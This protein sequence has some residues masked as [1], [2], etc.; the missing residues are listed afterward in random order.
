MATMKELRE[1]GVRAMTQNPP[2]DFSVADVN[3]SFREEIRALAGDAASFRRNKLDLFELMENIINDVLPQRVQ[4]RY[5]VWAEY[6]QIPNGAKAVFKKRL[7]KARA[8]SF[9]TKVGLD[10]VFETFRL[11]RTEFEVDTYGI[12]VAAVLSWERFLAGQEDLAEYLD[13]ILE[14]LDDYIFRMIAQAINSSVEMPRP[15]NTKATGSDFDASKVDA[16]INT[17]RAYGNPVLVCTPAFAAT[18]P[19]NYVVANS[20]TRISAQDAEDV[21]EY[22]YVKMYKGCPVMAIPNSFTDETNSEKT[23]SDEFLYIVPAVNSKLAN[24]VLEGG[25]EIDEFKNRD[26][27]M[28]LSAYQK[29]G[30]AILHTN[31]WAIYQNTS[32]DA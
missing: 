1:L 30:V 32:L 5:G 7:G 19:G 23:L 12:G 10:G 6:M 17:V 3:G 15:E 22:G 4:D 13:I 26:R 16:L 28:E 31:D 21:R 27:T 11:D 29:V 9:V 25:V 24:V 18:I 14:G 8:K 20:Q 2:Q